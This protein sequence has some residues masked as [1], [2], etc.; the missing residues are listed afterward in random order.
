MARC[1]VGSNLSEGFCERIISA[2]NQVM[3]PSNSVLNHEH[4]KKII[5]LRVNRAFM[6]WMREN[7]RDV[8]ATIAQESFNG[9]TMHGIRAPKRS[10]K[11]KQ[12]D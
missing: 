11:R 1:F 9:D 12:L 6:F 5:L 2:G 8:L 4:L 10:K 3:T 7:H